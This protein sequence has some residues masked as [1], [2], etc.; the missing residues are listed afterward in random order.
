MISPPSEI[1]CGL[2]RGLALSSRPPPQPH[3]RAT[4]IFVDE[5]DA[6]PHKDML[7]PRKRVGIADVAANFDVRNRVPVQPGGLGEIANCPI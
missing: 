1:P 6:G 4:T 3:T 5:L 2:L 7:D